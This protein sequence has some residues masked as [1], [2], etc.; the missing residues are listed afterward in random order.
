[1]VRLYNDDLTKQ[2]I[3]S[4]VHSA[5]D[6]YFSLVISDMIINSIT[7]AYPKSASGSDI[8]RPNDTISLQPVVLPTAKVRFGYLQS[9]YGQ[10]RYNTK[11]ETG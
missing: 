2:Y 9:E 11:E 3:I 4:F 10:I 1:M 7:L 8:N 6:S 5:N